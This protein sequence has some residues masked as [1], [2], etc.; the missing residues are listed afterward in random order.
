M[1]LQAS[2]GSVVFFMHIYKQDFWVFSLANVLSYREQPITYNTFSLFA[3]ALER[4]PKLESIIVFLEIQLPL[5][6]I[7][8][9]KCVH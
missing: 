9:T 1:F 7:V 8:R 5:K 3:M 4:I 2:P 6:I